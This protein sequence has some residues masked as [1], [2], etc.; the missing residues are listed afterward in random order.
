[1]TAW[2]VARKMARAEINGQGPRAKG[3]WVAV[4][5]GLAAALTVRFALPDTPIPAWAFLLAALVLVLFYWNTLRRVPLYLT[6]RTTTAALL[7]LLP[8][9]ADARFLDLGHGFGGTLLRLARARPDMRFDGIESAPMPY[10]VSWLWQ[11]LLHRANARVLYG[12]LWK[13]DL[14]PYDLVYAF[15]SPAPMSA[16]N[17]KAMR[18]MKP[19]SLLVSNS[20]AIAERTANEVLTLSDGRRTELFLYRF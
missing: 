14:G 7:A 3:V 11:G 17:A 9:R 1:M 16:L 8:S 2:M 19:G 15:L 10:A 4:A 6:N 20:F 13:L 5:I 18:E 12:D